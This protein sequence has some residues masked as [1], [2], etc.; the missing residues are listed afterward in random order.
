MTKVFIDGE[1]GTTGL[2]IGSRLASREDVTLLSIDPERKKDPDLRRELI[3]SADIAFL[4]L[5]DEAARESASLAEGSDT[6]IIDTSTAHRTSEGWAYGFPELSH[7]HFE[8]VKNG[9]RIAVP[10]CHAGG[11]AALV[12]PLVKCGI[13]PNDYPISAFSLTGYSGGGKKMI[14]EYESEE[15]E[16]LLD[17]PRQYGLGQNHKHLPEMQYIC[18]LAKK[19]L[20]SPIVADFYSGMEVSVPLYGELLTKKLC[21]KE[22]TEF[23]SDYYKNGLVGVRA[24]SD[25]N[26]GGFLSSCG[27]QNSDRMEITVCGNEDRILL[28]SRFDNLGKGASGAAIECMNISLGLPEGYGL[29]I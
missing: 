7:A 18:G 25:L 11:F 13:I 12:Y 29:E 9:K 26:E 3:H 23:Y 14:G 15:R 28:I 4:C 8:A 27:L 20:F 19:P 24:E 6:V 16:L 1:H 21:P 2:R 22:L 10:G 17:A 5:P